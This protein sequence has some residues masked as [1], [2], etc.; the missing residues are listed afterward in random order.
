MTIRYLSTYPAHS[1]S[2]TLT[3]C[4]GPKDKPHKTLIMKHQVFSYEDMIDWIFLLTK[5]CCLCTLQVYKYQCMTI[6]LTEVR[7]LVAIIL[8][9]KTLFVIAV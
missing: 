8:P 6:M 2:L 3:Q 1:L 5:V 4:C 9:M 7:Y